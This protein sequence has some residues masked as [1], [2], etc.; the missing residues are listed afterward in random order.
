[1]SPPTST[2]YA[3]S[4]APRRS[5]WQAAGEWILAWLAGLALAAA[6]A[7]V[8]MQSG[9]FDVAATA[10]HGPFVAWILHNTMIHSV[11]AHAPRG[12]QPVG[13]SPAQTQ[14]GL[15]LYQAH[16]AECH[17][18]PGVPRAGWTIG[19]TPT[20]PFLLDA[21]RHWSPGELQRI[22]ADGVKMSAMPGWR[23]SLSSED[24]EAIVTALEAMPHETQQSYAAAVGPHA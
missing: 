18:A 7:A 14:R 12:G 24:I 11:Q 16:C 19:L 21:A 4:A 1:M 2:P 9:A 17:G 23:T 6:A 22:V 5:L 3:R 20:P 15:T 8:V 10:P 13:F